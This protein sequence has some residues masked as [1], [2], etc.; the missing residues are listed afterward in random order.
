V[1]SPEALA[2]LAK[3]E[4]QGRRD[5]AAEYVRLGREDESERLLMQ[6]EVLSAFFP[7]R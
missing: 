5:A 3:R 7:A 2:A 6:A 4:I 1:L